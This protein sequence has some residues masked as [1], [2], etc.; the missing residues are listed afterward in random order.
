[1]SKWTDFVRTVATKYKG[2]IQAYQIGNETNI[3]TFWR[4]TNKELA[5]MVSS[6]TRVIKEVDPEALVVA[7]SQVF[8]SET[9]NTLQ[10]ESARNIWRLLS[11]DKEFIDALS[12]HWYSASTT[13]PV[14]LREL[15]T[16]KAQDPQL[17]CVPATRRHSLATQKQ[18]V[19]KH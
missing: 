5:A 3:T 6:A 19:A 14:A 10:M 9:A 18:V 16:N 4:G 12:F 13:K 8:V 1:M 17:Q 7:S 15:T 2:K 11:D